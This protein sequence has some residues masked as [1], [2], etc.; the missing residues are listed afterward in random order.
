MLPADDP[1]AT[2]VVCE[3]DAP[4]L[5]LLCDHLAADRFRPLPAPCASDALRLC[6][7]RHPDLLLLDLRLPDAFGLEVL[8]TIRAS[9]S[10]TDRF[11][12]DLPVIVLSGRGADADRVRTL[13][14]RPQLPQLE[15]LA[16]APDPAL[17]VEHGAAIL[18]LDREGGRGEERARERQAQRGSRYVQGT[19]HRVPSALSQTAGTPSRT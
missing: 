8:R 15:L 11:D 4:T 2:V 1:L 5:E 17:P 16:A 14:H 9:H 7:Y 13:A 19:V 12:P 3:D 6:G 18:E 10:A